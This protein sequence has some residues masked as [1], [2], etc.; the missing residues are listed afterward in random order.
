VRSK[1]E[2]AE[3]TIEPVRYKTMSVT[4]ASRES[5]KKP[6]ENSGATARKTKHRLYGEGGGK[7]VW[8]VDKKS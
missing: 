6:R 3:Q 7:N 8:S 4:P 1:L 5:K 2:A